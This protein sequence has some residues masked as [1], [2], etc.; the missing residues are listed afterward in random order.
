[1]DED[2]SG[3]AWTLQAGLGK[4]RVIYLLGMSALAMKLVDQVYIFAPNRSLLVRD[5]NMYSDYFKVIDHEQSVFHHTSPDLVAMQDS[6]LIFDEADL[7]IVD[8]YNRLARLIEKNM[9]VLV[10]AK[11]TDR[12]VQSYEK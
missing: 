4:S 10:S 12:K 8:H 2:V 5:K 1:M 3:Q 7:F 6:L 9:V 11:Y